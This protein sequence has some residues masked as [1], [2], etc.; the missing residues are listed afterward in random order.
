MADTYRLRSLALDGAACEITSG[1]LTERRDQVGLKS[2]YV[3]C[4]GP[5]LDLLDRVGDKLAVEMATDGGTF[6]GIAILTYVEGSEF[7]LQGTGPLVRVE[8]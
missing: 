1:R 2:W 3:V 6:S 5:S 8:S 4:L 7:E